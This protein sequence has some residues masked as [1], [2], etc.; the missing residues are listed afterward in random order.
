MKAFAKDVLRI[1]DELKIEKANVLGASFGGF[2]AQ[3]F[4]LTFPE[5]LDKLILACTS[6][7]GANHVK[8]NL[9][10]LM[11][12]ASTEE[13]NTSERIRKF[14]IPAFSDDFNDNH[15]ETVEEVCLLR[16]KS[17][18]PE[19]VYLAQLTA[20]TT[21]NFEDR[22]SEIKSETL[23]LSGDAD[24][25]VPMQNSINLSKNMPHAK[26]KIIEG[27][28]HMFF[29]EKAGEFNSTVKNFLKG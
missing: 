11:A 26:L 1:L 25:I 29:V 9:E 17:S 20:A 5:R 14:M 28:S 6:Y 3:K 4:A 8:P 21:F 23:I 18:V 2:V 27:G 12:F 24:R 19:E 15:A 16:E 10:V 22:V 7:G 13:M